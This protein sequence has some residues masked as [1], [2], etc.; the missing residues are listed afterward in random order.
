MQSD[1]TLPA[2]R[3]ALGGVQRGG[4]ELSRWAL[5]FTVVQAVEGK[6]CNWPF[7]S[8]TKLK[9]SPPAPFPLSSCVKREP[10][11]ERRDQASAEGVHAAGASVVKSTLKHFRKYLEEEENLYLE[12]SHI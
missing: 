3:C 11:S 4:Q 7:F 10:L 5:Q 1:Q 6:F 8:I 12:S 2:G 9:V